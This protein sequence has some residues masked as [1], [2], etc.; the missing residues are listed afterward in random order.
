L[1]VTQGERPLEVIEFEDDDPHKAFFIIERA[2]IRE[3]VT[4]WECD[5]KLGT[6]VLHADHHWTVT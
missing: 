2:R 6:L 1:R 5:V 3:P 4:I